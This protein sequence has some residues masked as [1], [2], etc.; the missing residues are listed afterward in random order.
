MLA[1][2]KITEPILETLGNFIVGP[3]KV[4]PDIELVMIMIVFPIVL[5][6]AQFW[7]IDNILKL[8]DQKTQ[9]IIEIPLE[10]IDKPEAD[11]LSNHYGSPDADKLSNHYG[12]PNTDK[13]SNHYGSSK[14]D[15][16]SN[17]YGQPETDKH[18]E[19]PETDNHYG[20]PETDRLS[21]HYEPPETDKEED[22]EITSDN[23]VDFENEKK[24]KD[25]H[26]KDFY[27]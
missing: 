5:N 23:V 13:L 16:L 18:Y 3:F 25:E 20:S 10:E 6:A 8:P 7:M 9:E 15:K 12:Q 11:K 27:L 17:H 26:I 21:N 1:F 22:V 14:T 24:N 2:I 4:N 19:S